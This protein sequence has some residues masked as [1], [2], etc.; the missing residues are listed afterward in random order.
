MYL[1]IGYQDS[2]G[3]DELFDCYLLAQGTGT[4]V[5]IRNNSN[6]NVCGPCLI[7]LSGGHNTSALSVF[8]HHSRVNLW[9]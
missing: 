6:V 5:P 4:L 9:Q 7:D 3:R 1:I 8:V 2:V